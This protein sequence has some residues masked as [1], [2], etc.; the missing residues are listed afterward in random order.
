MALIENAKRSATLV[1]AEDV[2]CWELKRADYDMIMRER[3]GIGT[4]LLTNLLRELSSRLRSTSAQLRE[5]VG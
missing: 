1:A 4:K 3:Q 5:T 2:M